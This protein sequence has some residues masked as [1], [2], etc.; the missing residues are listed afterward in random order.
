MASIRKYRNARPHSDPQIKPSVNICWASTTC[1]AVTIQSV[2]KKDWK[3]TAHTSC[4][5]SWPAPLESGNVAVWRRKATWELSPTSWEQGNPDAVLWVHRLEAWMR[6]WATYTTPP[7]ALN[8]E[9]V[10]RLESSRVQPHFT[11]AIL[12]F[13]GFLQWTSFMILQW[14]LLWF[15][16]KPIAK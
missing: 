13:L 12:P 6:T 7:T 14:Q 9:Q 11:F 3:C 5:C 4:S 15:G 2:L 10:E 1:R 16:I 8:E